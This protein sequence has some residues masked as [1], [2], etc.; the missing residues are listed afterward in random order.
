MYLVEWV[1][2]FIKS[3]MPRFVLACCQDKCKQFMLQPAILV[4]CYI[5]SSFGKLGD[6][7][8]F[9]FVWS[10]VVVY[11]QVRNCSLILVGSRVSSYHTNNT[12]KL[13]AEDLDQISN[14]AVATPEPVSELP[15]DPPNV[16]ARE[17]IMVSEEAKE[18]EV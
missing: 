7:A 4:D 3:H 18:P 17:E 14:P 13:T 8:K 16:E 9:P 15:S 5:D 2:S 12:L 6:T 10:Y 11:L 1:K